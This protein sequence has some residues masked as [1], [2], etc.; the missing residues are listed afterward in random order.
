[1]LAPT[2]TAAANTI[3]SSNSVR[4]ANAGP[5]DPSS[6]DCELESEEPG[7]A[8]RSVIKPVSTTVLPSLMPQVDEAA[9]LGSSTNPPKVKQLSGEG[10][11]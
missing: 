11:H 9:R 6:A 7:M 3:I 4:E 8:A 2:K 1:M 10:A 5:V